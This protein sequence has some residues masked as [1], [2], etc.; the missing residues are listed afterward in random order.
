VAIALEEKTSD[1]KKIVL[2]PSIGGQPTELVRWDTPPGTIGD[3]AWTPDAKGILLVLQKYVHST[4]MELWHVSLDAPEPR[5]IMEADLGGWG[6]MRVHP[7]GRRIA[8]NAGR[9]FHELWVME[10]IGSQVSA[11]ASR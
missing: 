2:I 9:R 3:I 6:A 4:P 5:K 11:S 1:A 7:D 8:F 10:N